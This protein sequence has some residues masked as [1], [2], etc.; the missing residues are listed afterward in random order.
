MNGWH[1][2]MLAKT[3]VDDRNRD[4]EK[5]HQKMKAL[6]EIR[7]SKDHH[8]LLENVGTWIKNH[9]HIGKANKH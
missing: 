5:R 3:Y 7:A 8:N 6:E 9:S 4:A 1:E 2:V